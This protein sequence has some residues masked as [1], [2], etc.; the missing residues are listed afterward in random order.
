MPKIF[1]NVLSFHVQGE[2]YN[3]KEASPESIINNYAWTQK[4]VEGEIHIIGRHKDTR[5]RINKMVKL[6]KVKPWIKP[7]SE[8]FAQL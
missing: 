6:S 5:G 4:D 7:K 1:D 3:D 2:I 8:L